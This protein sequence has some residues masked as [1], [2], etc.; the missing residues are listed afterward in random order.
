MTTAQ[1]AA[2]RTFAGALVLGLCLTGG[3]AFAAETT[4]AW[5][6]VT[7]KIALMT[8]D[9]LTAFD[10]AVDTVNGVVTLHGKVP[11]DGER[12]KAEKVAMKIEGVKSVRNLMQ[13]VPNAR[14][15]IAERPDAD[16]KTDAEAAFKANRQVA[17]SGISVASVNNG[18]VRLSG[19]ARSL[20]AYLEAVQIANAVRGVR[21]VSTAVVVEPGT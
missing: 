14:R 17:E 10:V 2:G 1:I 13:I 5:I 4:D 6:T 18:V 15:E 9:N 20:E 7:T 12:S 19:R 16:V 11:N 8:A 21:R 3:V